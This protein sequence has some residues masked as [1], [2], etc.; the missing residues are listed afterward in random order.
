MLRHESGIIS[1]T[2]SKYVS[3][4][5]AVGEITVM[6]PQ[7]YVYIYT[8]VRILIAIIWWSK[9]IN[10]QTI[11]AGEYTVN[12]SLGFVSTMSAFS[13]LRGGGGSLKKKIKSIPL[14]IERNQS[15]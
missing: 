8:V 6:T 11:R 3:A 9:I 1:R 14:H 5:Q 13:F 7:S 4:I 15:P 12:F 10:V 2:R